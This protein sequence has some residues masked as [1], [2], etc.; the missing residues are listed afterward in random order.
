[1]GC[2]AE[3]TAQ[4]GFGAEIDLDAVNVAVEGMPPEV[5]AVG[6]TQERLLWVVPPDVHGRGAAHLQRRVHASARSRYN[7]RATVIGR[8]TA[9][10]AVRACATAARS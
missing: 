6:E 5:I 7:A 9:A 3:I 1:M 8:V 2:S 10:T 4:G